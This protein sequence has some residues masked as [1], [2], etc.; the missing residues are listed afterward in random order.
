MARYQID[1]MLDAAL[2]YVVDNTNARWAISAD[3][4]TYG[5]AVTAKL[6]SATITSTAFTIANGDT[7]G[8][9]VTCAVVSGVSVTTTG[10]AI[11]FVLVN[12]GTSALIYE[13]PASVKLLPAASEVTFGAF[14]ITIRDS[15]AP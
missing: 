3:V 5:S 12:T 7:D 14:D 1:A 4:T 10:S 11:N 15:S 8:R 13:T 6:A 9:K 2:Q